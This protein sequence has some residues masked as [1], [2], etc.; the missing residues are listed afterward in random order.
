MT[1][2]TFARQFG[3]TSLVLFAAGFL[4]G[5]QTMYYDA[6]EKIGIEK[7]DILVD[8]VENARE[9]QQDAKE[10]FSSALEKFIAV[11]NYSGGELEKQYKL[12][13]DEYEDSSSRA[14]AV[15]EK[16]QS[17]EDVASA[18]FEEW[19]SEIKQYSSAE[20]R[21]ASEQQLNS[22]KKS[23]A[24]LIKAMKSAEKK[25]KP[26]LTAFNDRVLF[27]KHNLNANAITSL[28]TQRL[29]VEN[30]IQTLIKDMNKSIAEADKFI[31]SMSG[32]AG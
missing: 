31:S 26:V 21:R 3:R 11:T 15:R 22:T 8:R 5:C 24:N 23:Y 6:M 9:A 14:E 32:S 20:L 7:R 13:K 19:E 29:S 4:F 28:K 10:Q 17:V 16:I 18:L 12:L 27:L 2:Q 30:D 25:I 1:L